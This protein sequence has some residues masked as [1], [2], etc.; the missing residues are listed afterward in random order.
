MTRIKICGITNAEDARAAVDYG[1]HALGFNFVPLSP[2]Y[3]YRQSE[4]LFLPW[5][6]PPFVDRVA[7]YHRIEDA[8]QNL[9]DCLF[10]AVQFYEGHPTSLSGERRY[11]RA[12]RV[13]DESCFA[14]VAACVPHAHALLLDAY[15]AD[16]LGGTGHTFNWELAR[17]IG[18]RFELPIILAGG[19]TPDNVADAIAAV[20]PYAVDVSSGVEAE[21]A[22]KDHVMLKAFI[23]AVQRADAQL[24]DG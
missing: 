5:D 6:L 17:E 12:I 7:I 14:E 9:S 8:E 3:V 24:S 21:P 10:G 2:R 4:P 18:R 11:I 16:M 1:A 22:R 20:R 15:S 23:R 19:L 13:R